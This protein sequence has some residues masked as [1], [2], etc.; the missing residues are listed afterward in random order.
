MIDAKTN[1][2]HRSEAATAYLT[3]HLILRENLDTS[4]FGRT[5]TGGLLNRVLRIGEL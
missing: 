4:R 5:E 3:F 2:G 1:I